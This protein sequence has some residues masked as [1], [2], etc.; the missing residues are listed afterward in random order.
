MRRWMLPMLA[1]I[2]ILG[3]CVCGCQ[4]SVGVKAQELIVRADDLAT[5]NETIVEKLVLDREAV[6]EDEEVTAIYNARLLKLVTSTLTAVW[7]EE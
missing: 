3:L 6:T 2:L 7:K 4:T 1:V 5:Q